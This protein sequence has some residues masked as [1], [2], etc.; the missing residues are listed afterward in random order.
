MLLRCY[1][2]KH[3]HKSPSYADCYATPEWHRFSSFHAWAITQPWEGNEL[4]KDLLVKGNKVYSPKFCI[5]ISQRLNCFL[6]DH[7]AARGAWPIGVSLYCN[8]KKFLAHCSNPNTGKCEYLG[9][10]LTPELAHEAWRAKKHGYALAYADEQADPRIAEAL[11]NR[12]LLEK[13]I[14]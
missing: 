7:A 12:Y 6:T 3:R 2:E 13:E 10:F 1:S 8:G 11:R 5:F 9:G 14:I 4:D